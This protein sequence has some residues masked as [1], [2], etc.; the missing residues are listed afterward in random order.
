M[1]IKFRLSEIIVDEI[2][3]GLKRLFCNRNFINKVGLKITFLDLP[4]ELVKGWT[5]VQS[6]MLNT[7]ISETF[8]KL[9][10]I[11]K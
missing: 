3:G 6:K 2:K 8:R 4:P 9:K 11:L 5:H 7:I 10:S 1:R